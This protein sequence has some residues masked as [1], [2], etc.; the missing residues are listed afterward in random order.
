MTEMFVI[1]LIEP[2]YQIYAARTLQKDRTLSRK[3]TSSDQQTESFIDDLTKGTLRNMRMLWC[4]IPE[5]TY[6][7]FC[8]SV[9]TN[10][11]TT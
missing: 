4:E 2:L 10:I 9:I 6:L 3:R 8:L 5:V 7:V 1:L 11:V